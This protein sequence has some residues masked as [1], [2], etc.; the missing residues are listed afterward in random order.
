MAINIRRVGE[1]AD[2]SVTANKLADSAVDLGSDK[3]TGQVPS[4][5]IQNGAIIE[6]KL[7]DL[8]ISTGKLK[9]NVVTLAK[10]DDDMRLRSFVGD[11]TIV[12]VTGTTESIEKELTI[13]KH[14]VKFGATKIRVLAGLYTSDAAFTASLKIYIDSEASARLELTSVSTT[15]ELVAGE[16]DI[17]D[18]AQGRHIIQAA[19]VSS[20]V[21]GTAYN[22]LID[23]MIVT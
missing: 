11:E 5:K 22:D 2:G 21:A 6:Q 23:I 20:D 18:L 12:S 19:L 16:F 3:V 8:A 13:P 15:S 17:S 14:A 10:A 9:D 4:T 1:V 7:A